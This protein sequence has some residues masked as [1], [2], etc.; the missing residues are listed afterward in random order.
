MRFQSYQEAARCLRELRERF[1]NYGLSLYPKKTRLLEFGRFAA[2]QRQERG[3]SQP[4]TFAF[5]GFTHFCGKTRKG[6]F[7]VGRYRWPSGCEPSW[8]RSKELFDVEC[9]RLS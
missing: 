9:T 7:K 2:D 4:E 8:E 3:E 6:W 1:A 5:L